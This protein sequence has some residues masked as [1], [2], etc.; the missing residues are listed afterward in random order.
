MK[1]TIEESILKSWMTFSVLRVL[2]DPQDY[3]ELQVPPVSM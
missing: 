3:Q 1:F 2:G